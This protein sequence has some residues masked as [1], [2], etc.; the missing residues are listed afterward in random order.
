MR[1]WIIM[2]KTWTLSD[3]LQI[4][5]RALVL[6]SFCT[7]AVLEYIS[8]L[9]SLL[10]LKG[11]IRLPATTT[12]TVAPSSSTQRSAV[13]ESSCFVMLPA[14]EEDVHLG[15]AHQMYKAGSYK[16]ALEHCN[17]VYESNPLYL[18]Y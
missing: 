14:P 15:V 12:T 3:L 6:S 10:M 17:D 16:Q 11:Q 13:V 4:G 2:A 18:Y 5:P 9:M 7:S 8:Q 1:C